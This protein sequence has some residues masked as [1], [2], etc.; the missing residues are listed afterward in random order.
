MEFITRMK[1]NYMTAFNNMDKSGS[2]NMN[3]VNHSIILYI[4]VLIGIYIS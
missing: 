2:M 1:V 3:V 4:Y